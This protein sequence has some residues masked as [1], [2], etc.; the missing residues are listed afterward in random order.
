MA[1][2]AV[3]Q[4]HI[5]AIQRAAK[6]H[7]EIW[8]DE[9]RTRVIHTLA[10][11]YASEGVEFGPLARAA[12]EAQIARHQPRLVSVLGGNAHNMIALMRHPRPYDFLL[13]G[14]AEGPPM[15]ADAELVPEA[16]VRAAME[17]RLETDFWR[18]QMLH[19]IAGPFIH[20]ESP[21]PIIGDAFIRD[22]AEVYFRDTQDREIV[23]GSPGLR[24]RMWR[25]TSRILKERVEALG[26]RFMPVPR[27]VLDAD[28]FLRL[29]FAAD[30]T[31][32]NEAYGE[33]LIRAIE[34]F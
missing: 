25:L 2:L 12:I 17:A 20:V 15:D 30:P 32:G 6:T 5:G 24:W 3:G 10:E 31:H 22:R 33:R 28:G 1:I 14:E 8:P 23:P 7:R 29:D 26:G 18:L 4:S 27:E 9:L 13:S 19:D 11:P 16:L 34:D 21:P